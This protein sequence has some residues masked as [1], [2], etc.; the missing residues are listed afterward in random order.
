MAH[1]P[2]TKEGQLQATRDTN[3]KRFSCSEKEILAWRNSFI[4]RYSAITSEHFKAERIDF[5]Y[6]HNQLSLPA[7]INSSTPTCLAKSVIRLYT[8]ASKRVTVILYHTRHGTGT[9]LYQGLDCNEWDQTECQLLSNIVADFCRKEDLHSLRSGLVRLPFS[10][11]QDLTGDVQLLTLVLTPREAHVSS[12]PQLPSSRQ[13]SSDTNIVMTELA[14]AWFDERLMKEANISNI[15]SQ[16]DT[17]KENTDALQTPHPGDYCDATLSVELSSEQIPQLTDVSHTNPPP[18]YSKRT[19]RLRRRTL[20]P[21]NLFHKTIQE[22]LHTLQNNF[23]NFGNN[24]FDQIADLETRFISQLQNTKTATKNELKQHITHHVD[25][26]I[27]S[28]REIKDHMT[29]LEKTIASL[30]RENHSI[31]TQIGNLQSDV[32]R[33]TKNN[34]STSCASTQC[35]IQS[36]AVDQQTQTTLTGAVH[37]IPKVEEEPD[38]TSCDIQTHT[39]T[40]TDVSLKEKKKS[41]ANHCSVYLYLPG[42]TTQLSIQHHYRSGQYFHPCPKQ[43]PFIVRRQSHWRKQ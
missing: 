11:L 34:T 9:L 5:D 19:K 26:I 28:I 35:D 32:K 13:S 8:K 27:I 31:K 29:Q 30:S 37:D 12:T 24:F 3:Q 40:K 42:G 16:T 38:S 43:V 23:D 4:Y 18:K 1:P 33:L 2:P 39:K 15:M 22:K 21:K 20:C 10:F 36:A 25:S 41:P 6:E 14:S 17:T 7:W